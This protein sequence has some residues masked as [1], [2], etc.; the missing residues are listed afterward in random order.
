MNEE[1]DPDFRSG[2][3]EEEDETTPL[4]GTGSLPKQQEQLQTQPPTDD[5]N[6]FLYGTIS[7]DNSQLQQQLQQSDQEEQHDVESGIISRT[8]AETLNMPHRPHD[9]PCLY[10]FHIFSAIAV[11]SSTCLIATQIIP[12]VWLANHNQVSENLLT[13]GLKSYITL[14]CVM[15]VVVEA[16]LKVPLI[17][18]SPLMQ[19]YFSRGFIYSFI[20]LVCVEESYSERIKDSIT[21]RDAFHV[22][23]IA[24]FMQISSW[25]ML[26]VGLV[27]MLFGMCCLKRLRDRLKQNEIEAWRKYREDMKDYKRRQ[28][29]LSAEEG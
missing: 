10:I 24:I 11:M 14:F 6:P 3:M 2:I 12:I 4:F 19:N 1:K 22:G 15:F 28:R 21:A 18:S 9:N 16:D 20:G 13:L 26:G 27:Y 7:T 5:E 25:F 29:E 8:T 17:R 23:W